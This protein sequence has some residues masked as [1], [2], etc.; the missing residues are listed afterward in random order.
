MERRR[1]CVPLDA[2]ARA[3][4]LVEVTDTYRL[5]MRKIDRLT[6]ERRGRPGFLS[7]N[8]RNG[9]IGKLDRLHS[10]AKAALG[11]D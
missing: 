4:T 9:L 5:A 3:A 8:T 7:R 10:S 1:D 6:V 2:A 11:L